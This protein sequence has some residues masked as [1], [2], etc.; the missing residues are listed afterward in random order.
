MTKTTTVPCPLVRSRRDWHLP[1][2]PERDHAYFLA[3]ELFRR[4]HPIPGLRPVP[5]GVLPMRRA[6]QHPRQERRA[7]GTTARVVAHGAS[8]RDHRI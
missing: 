5:P 4:A 1:T 8:E 3:R 2:T 6:R 7:V